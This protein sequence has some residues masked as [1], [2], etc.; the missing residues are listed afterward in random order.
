M[1]HR[2]EDD[3]GGAFQGIFIATLALI[4]VVYAGVDLFDLG[5]HKVI[6]PVIGGL[7]AALRLLSLPHARAWI[8]RY[9]PWLDGHVPKPPER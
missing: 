6:A 1:T 4:P 5:G 8:K 7:T 2:K 9:V 3:P